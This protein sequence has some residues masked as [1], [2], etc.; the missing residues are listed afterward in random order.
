MA[1]NSP[2]SPVEEDVLLTSCR[3]KQISEVSMSV[4]ALSSG[5]SLLSRPLT[6]T[7]APTS[8]T[9]LLVNLA[10]MRVTH[11]HFRGNPN[12]ESSVEG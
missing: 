11:Q 7:P 9:C 5:I 12:T 8:Q 6:M 10:V 3:S 2:L 4:P 1:F